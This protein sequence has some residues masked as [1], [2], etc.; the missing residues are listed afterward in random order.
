[1][2]KKYFYTCP[3]RAGQSRK[4]TIYNEDFSESTDTTD[5]SEVKGLI[6]VFKRDSDLK[7]ESRVVVGILKEKD[8][9]P[10]EMW[11]KTSESLVNEEVDKIMKGCTFNHCKPNISEAAGRIGNKFYSTTTAEIIGFVQKEGI[12]YNLYRKRSGEFFIY[13]A[14]LTTTPSAA[15][16]IIHA[17]EKRIQPISYDEAKLI[18]KEIL[19]PKVYEAHFEG[20]EN[21]I[22][23][24][25]I[26]ISDRTH[27]TLKR[28]AAIH[29]TSISEIIEETISPFIKIQFLKVIM[30]EFTHVTEKMKV[31]SKEDI[32]KMIYEKYDASLNTSDI[33]LTSIHYNQ[34]N[35]K[36]GDIY[37]NEEFEQPNLAIG[38]TMYRAFAIDKDNENEFKT[39]MIFN[40]QYEI[41][42]ITDFSSEE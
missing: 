8:C 35:I 13:I 39:Q 28:N 41:I 23:T 38:D 11:A 37:K 2:N 18:A 17:N 5:L 34:T 25:N 15:M 10:V 9:L 21:T 22:R 31:Y 1:M 14:P 20:S 42:D 16:G 3:E 26:S 33:E 40:N 6:Q 7:P 4:W 29:N 12:I 19:D 32:K 27:K 24:L 30:K 36:T